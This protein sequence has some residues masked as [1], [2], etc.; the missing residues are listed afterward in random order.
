[1]VSVLGSFLSVVLIFISICQTASAQENLYHIY[2]MKGSR[3]GDRLVM[4]QEMD[5]Q[6]N[7]GEPELAH[8]WA[9]RRLSYM[10]KNIQDPGRPYLI[11]SNEDQTTHS[12]I[13]LFSESKEILID[14]ILIGE[15]SSFIACDNNSLYYTK[16]LEN[17]KWYLVR[18]DGKNETLL[19]E[20]E[21]EGGGLYA[22]TR[23][24]YDN[25]VFSFSAKMK[26]TEEETA[27]FYC[28]E[29]G[30]A[31]Y[32]DKGTFQFWISNYEL[33]YVKGEQVWHYNILTD[34]AEQMKNEKGDPILVPKEIIHNQTIWNTPKISCS[35]D[36]AFIAYIVYEPGQLLF[37]KSPDYP[38]WKLH[39]T[40]LVTGETVIVQK[41]D[42]VIDDDYEIF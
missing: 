29:F 10:I 39:V 4:K 11:L 6:M 23:G 34:K 30:K 26:T 28:T 40:S 15:K 3:N 7:V 24:L 32:I 21:V 18:N 22:S 37:W 9:P 25:G 17:S 8:S 36:G 16:K 19:Y 38:R 31:Q 27:I 14:E 1:M 20:Y 2:W 41:G 12:V 42:G 5:G 35:A 33:G 13:S